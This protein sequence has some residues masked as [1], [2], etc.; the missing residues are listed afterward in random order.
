MKP[1]KIPTFTPTKAQR[2]WLEQEKQRTGNTFASIIRT[3]IQKKVDANDSQK[4]LPM[5]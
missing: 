3:L 5:G 2:D 4:H 1:V